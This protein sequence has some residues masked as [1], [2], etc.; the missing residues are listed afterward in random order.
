MSLIKHMPILLTR[1]VCKWDMCM[2]TFVTPGV[3]SWSTQIHTPWYSWHRV[4]NTFILYRNN[5]KHIVRLANPGIRSIHDIHDIYITPNK[6]FVTLVIWGVS[7]LVILCV[8]SVYELIRY[9][10]SLFFV[11]DQ[12]AWIK[13]H[14]KNINLI[15]CS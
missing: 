15:F 14:I 13:F 9:K 10:K 5:S 1:E 12:S 8:N 11:V 2:V 4:S 3:E 6:L 7:T